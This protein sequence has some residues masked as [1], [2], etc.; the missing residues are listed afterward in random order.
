MIPVVAVS[1]V[2]NPLNG[3]RE[4][5]SPIRGFE[6]FDFIQIIRQPFGVVPALRN[7]SPGVRNS[8]VLKDIYK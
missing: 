2:C 7:D 3:T 4:G 8:D 5:V 1:A 6:F